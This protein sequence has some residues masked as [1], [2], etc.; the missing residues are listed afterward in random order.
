MLT[1]SLFNKSYQRY[2][3]RGDK[4]RNMCVKSYFDKIMPYLRVL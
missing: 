3:F 4:M 1:S 2:H